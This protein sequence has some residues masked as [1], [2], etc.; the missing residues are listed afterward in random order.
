MKTALVSLL[1]FAGLACG[2]TMDTRWQPFQFLIGKWDGGGTGQPGA[3]QGAFSFLPELNGQ[4]LVRRS[5]NQLASGP[6]HEDWMIVYS[7]GPKDAPRAIYFDSEGHAIHYAVT[8]PAKNAAVFES[9]AGQAGPK[10][11]L[12]YVLDGKT[13]NGKFEVDGKTYL[14]WTAA[15]SE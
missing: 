13:L 2:Q 8:F 14:T 11:R 10:Y 1:L 15:K 6:R 12:S 5:F 4:V 7:D 9:E 3:G